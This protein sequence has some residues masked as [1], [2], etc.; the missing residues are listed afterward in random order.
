MKKAC[1]KCGGS[2]ALV[3]GQWRCRPCVNEYQAEYRRA[4]PEKTK[5]YRRKFRA[6]HPE[7][8]AAE[9]KEWVARNRDKAREHRKKYLESHPNKRKHV[10]LPDSYL[11]VMLTR[12]TRIPGEAIPPALIEAKRLQILILRSVKNEKC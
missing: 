11:R 6:N 1:A 3:S 4:H 10:T 8:R 5:E 7:K 9:H 12:H 2:L